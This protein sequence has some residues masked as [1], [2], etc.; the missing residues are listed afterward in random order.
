M[1]PCYRTQHRV[2]FFFSNLAAGDDAAE[3]ALRGGSFKRR[4]EAAPGHVSINGP[5][6]R[7]VTSII[8][9]WA[10]KACSALYL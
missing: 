8:S 9:F 2:V 10:E 1:A 5:I 3:A 4:R 6:E 7:N